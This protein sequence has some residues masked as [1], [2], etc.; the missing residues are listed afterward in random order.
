MTLNM[1]AI[2]DELNGF[3]TPIPFPN[4]ETAQRYFREQKTNNLTIKETPSDFSLWEM[5]TFDNETGEYIS[6]VKM[7]ERG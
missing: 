1:Y 3:I 2:K 6:N 4:T 5:G 7:I